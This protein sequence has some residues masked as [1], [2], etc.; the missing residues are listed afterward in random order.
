MNVSKM[1]LKLSDYYDLY[2][3]REGSQGI[4]GT[5]TQTGKLLQ[6][7]SYPIPGMESVVILVVDHNV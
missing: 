4:L 1:M 3:L 6:T 5:I 2:N 7:V